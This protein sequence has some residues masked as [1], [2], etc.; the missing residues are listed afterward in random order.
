VREGWGHSPLRGAVAGRFCR[1]RDVRQGDVVPE[2]L[3]QE[4]D[5]D[6]RHSLPHEQETGRLVHGGPDG[7]GREVALP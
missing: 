4:V 7:C 2:R 6:D 5:R 1:C 3:P